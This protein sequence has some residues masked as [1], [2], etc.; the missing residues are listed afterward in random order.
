MSQMIN[1]LR[2]MRELLAR[3]N[4]WTQGAYGRRPDG[5]TVAFVNREAYEGASCLCIMGAACAVAGPSLLKDGVS[6]VILTSDIHGL[7]APV[8]SLISDPI[9]IWNDQEGRTQEQVLDLMDRAI[10]K[11]KQIEASAAI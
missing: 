6:T 4:G 3:P 10:E 9:P 2:K 7:V 1:N 11:Q 8:R 5:S